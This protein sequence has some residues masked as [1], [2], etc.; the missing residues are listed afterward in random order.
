MRNLAWLT[1]QMVVVAVLLSLSSQAQDKGP[2][3]APSVNVKALQTNPKG[4]LKK[5]PVAHSALYEVNGV[6][7]EKIIASL[8]L[9]EKIGQMLFLGFGG[10]VL[11]STIGSFLDEKKPGAVAL[12]SRNIKNVSQTLKL[13]RDVRKHDP[14]GIPMF[15]SV[16]QEGGDVVRIRGPVTI[17]PSNMAIGATGSVELAKRAGAALGKDLSILGF[18]MNLAPVLDVN[19]NP[20]NPVIGIRSFGEDPQAVGDL[21]VAYAL[22]LQGEGVSAVAKHFPGHGDTEVDSHHEMPRLMHDRERL[23]R[24]ELPPFR[25]ALAE[26]VDALMTAHIALPKIAE[27]PDM[28]ATVSKNVLTK[29]L[30]QEFGYEGLLMTDGLEMEG[31]VSRYGSGEAAVRAVEAGADMVMVLW[32]KEKKDEVQRS[33]LQAVKSGRLSEARIDQSVR[34]VLRTKARR[35]LFAQK[36]LD[37]NVAMKKLNDGAHRVVV[38]EIAEAAITLVKNDSL[39]PLQKESGKTLVFSTEKSI[40]RRLQKELGAKAY[41]L[42]KTKSKRRK[43]NEHRQLAKLARNASRIVIA[44]RNALDGALVDAFKKQNPNVKIIVGSLESPYMVN[45]FNKVSAYVCA[46]AFRRESAEA[47]ADVLLGKRPAT[48]HLPVSLSPEYPRGHGLSLKSAQVR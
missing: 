14:K 17:V 18:N 43:R 33:L 23:F 3:S 10:T 40:S 20:K 47:L 5:T 30:R 22:G 45:D 9:K 26:G 15:V 21:G 1:T 38:K 48:G 19:S 29:L 36:L 12:F 37:A 11:D 6:D 34:R 31:I 8:T 35:G 13:I 42:S 25:K 7:V 16:D 44:S 46:Y 41:A 32:F 2:A 24:V 39:L 28:P 27:D 4:E